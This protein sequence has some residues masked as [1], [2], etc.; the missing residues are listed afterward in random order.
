[1]KVAPMFE[2]LQALGTIT[3]NGTRSKRDAKNTRVILMSPR[4][5][6]IF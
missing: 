5:K 1:M 3:K 2:A 6:R 4:G